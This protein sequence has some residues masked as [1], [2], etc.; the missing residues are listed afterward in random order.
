MYFKTYIKKVFFGITKFNQ[1]VLNLSSVVASYVPNK[2]GSL[3]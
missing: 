1:N 3:V 2:Q